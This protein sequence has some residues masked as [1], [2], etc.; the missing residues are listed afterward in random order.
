MG[1]LFNASDEWSFVIALVIGIAFGY[2]LESAG[3]S[4]S[5]KLAGVFYG[6]DFV[7]LKVFFTA[8]ITAAI[9]LLFFEYFGWID[10]S[11]IWVNRFY[12]GSAIVGGAIMGFGF[13]IGGFC[14][15]TSACASAIGKIDA[16]LFLVG[17]IIG[18]IIFDAFY[19]LYGKF[20]KAG[21]LGPVKIYDS[22]GMNREVFLLIFVVFAIF[23]FVVTGYIQ[24]RVSQKTKKY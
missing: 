8:A 2:I 21:N 10:L 4:S 6:Y 18:V 1:P 15:G 13:I 12:T 20:Y 14:P 3:F 22:L 16:M 11:E 23:A 17:F 7:V 9:G 24:K 5:R 19:P